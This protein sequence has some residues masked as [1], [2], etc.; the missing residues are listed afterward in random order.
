MLQSGM[1]SGM[2]LAILL[3][4]LATSAGG[5]RS[6]AADKKTE[7][8]TILK[9]EKKIAILASKVDFATALDLD[10]PGISTI[11][12][13]IDQARRDP[14]P[15]ALIL[16]S[17]ELGAME[18]VS[19]KKAS[20]TAAGLLK[21]ATEVAGY[22]NQPAEMRTAAKL[23]GTGAEAKK[24]VAQANKAEKAQQARKLSEE[25]PKGITRDLHVDN[26][27]RWY[28]LVYVNYVYRGTVR[29]YGDLLVD[30][31]DGAYDTTQLSADAPS[32]PYTWSRSVPE[33][34]RDFTWILY[35]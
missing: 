14:N 26:R 32:T 16:L 3:G 23:L 21:E 8:R 6:H 30:V 29:P 7:K 4:L 31:G 33:P 11:G 17:K 25:R 15:I 13:R 1:R 28:I 9:E 24:L 19:D 20:L 35:P 5:L 34:V 10:L 12:T 18:E 22:R 2:G 27:T